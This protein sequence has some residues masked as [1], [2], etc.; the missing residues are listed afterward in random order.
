MN[1][2][3]IIFTKRKTIDGFQSKY[4]KKHRINA[5]IILGSL[6][7]IGIIIFQVFW[8]YNSFKSNEKLLNKSIV[9]ALNQVAFDLADFN[10]NQN[11]Q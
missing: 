8:I 6:S 1:A 3:I 2:L 7:L 9:L 11:P 10:E 4:M 5:V